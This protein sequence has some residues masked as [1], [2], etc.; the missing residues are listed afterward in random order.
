[1]QLAL[2]SSH[3]LATGA[4]RSAAQTSPV[5]EINIVRMTTTPNDPTSPC[6]G[7]RAHRTGRARRSRRTGPAVALTP[8]ERRVAELVCAGN[9]NSVVA[10]E[11]FVSV[12]TVGSHLRSIYAKLQVNSRVALLLA[13][14][15]AAA[16]EAAAATD[17]V[18]RN[19]SPAS[20]AYGFAHRA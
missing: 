6:T 4:L 13:L 10:R 7:A 17:A 12:N 20:G 9:S 2:P 18:R 5:D 16:R 14:Q 19:T 3:R 15:A 1:M 11:L 8:A